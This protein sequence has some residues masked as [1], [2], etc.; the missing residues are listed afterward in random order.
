[1]GGLACPSSTIHYRKPIGSARADAGTE[2]RRLFR[3][4]SGYWI[5]VDQQEVI[6]RLALEFIHDIEAASPVGS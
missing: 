1:M 5:V 4:Q 3:I 6:A 2:G